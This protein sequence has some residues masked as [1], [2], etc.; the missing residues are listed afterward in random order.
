MT[1]EYEEEDEGGIGY[2]D[3]VIQYRKDHPNELNTEIDVIIPTR[4][5]EDPKF[6]KAALESIKEQKGAYQFNILRS[7]HPAGQ[8]AAV[9][10]A[11][12]KGKAKYICCLESD[13]TWHSM[14]TQIQMNYMENYDMVT[15]SQ[16]LFDAETGKPEDIFQ[17]PTPSGWRM[18][19]D[20]WDYV[21]GFN[22]NLK[23]HVDNWFL[24]RVNQNSDMKRLHV[25]S[26]TPKDNLSPQL[27]NITK[28][29]DIVLLQQKLVSQPLVRKMVNP[30]GGL[31]RI[32]LIKSEKEISKKEY[33]LM[34]KTFGEIPW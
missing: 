27:K 18:H 29:S 14:K 9:N 15:C 11:A 22:E 17:Y 7:S 28:N 12:E 10:E 34:F 19:R 4:P 6:L 32:S 33:Q 16:L 31:A 30:N 1:E 13:D 3:A 8:A 2:A 26:G 20:V 25:T 23:Y 24:G 5:G 21:R